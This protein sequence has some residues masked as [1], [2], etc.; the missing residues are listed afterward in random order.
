VW[1]GE[2][3][4]IVPRAYTYTPYWNETADPALRT[5]LETVLLD[6]TADVAAVMAQAAQAQAAQDAQQALDAAR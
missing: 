4:H 2:L 3:N 1:I 5:A 6:P